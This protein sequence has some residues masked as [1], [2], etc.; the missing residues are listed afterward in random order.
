NT[1]RT[2]AALAAN[3]VVVARENLRVQDERYRAGATTILDLLTAQVDLTE[4]EAGLVQARFT[5]RLARA[6]VEAILGRRFSGTR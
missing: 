2:S 5:T 1:A 6:G 4:A 3:A